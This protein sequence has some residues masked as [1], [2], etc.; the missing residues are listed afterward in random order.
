MRVAK[1]EENGLDTAKKTIISPAYCTI[2]HSSYGSWACVFSP[3]SHTIS[4]FLFSLACS[5]ANSLFLFLP[6][7]QP[8]TPPIEPVSAF[9]TPSLVVPLF[10]LTYCSCYFFSFSIAQLKCLVTLQ[11]FAGANLCLFS[12]GRSTVWGECFVCVIACVLFNNYSVHFNATTQNVWTS[13]SQDMF[14]YLYD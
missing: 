4:P 7:S 11:Q 5:F 14:P 2:V 8:S 1:D 13:L 3:L 10:S 12:L 9:Y 6:P